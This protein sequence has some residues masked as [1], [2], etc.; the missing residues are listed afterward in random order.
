M[1]SIMKSFLNVIAGGSMRWVSALSEAKTLPLALE[2]TIRQIQDALGQEK[3]DLCLIFVSSE[4]RSGYETIAAAI[5][6]GL[7]PKVIM[8]CSGGGVVGS[9]REIEHEPALTITAAVLPDV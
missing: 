8:G 6:S 3:P 2:E 7:K 9:G 1:S 5:Q 4:F